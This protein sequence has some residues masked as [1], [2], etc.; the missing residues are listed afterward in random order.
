MKYVQKNHEKYFAYFGNS[1]MAVAFD[2]QRGK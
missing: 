2:S 1:K